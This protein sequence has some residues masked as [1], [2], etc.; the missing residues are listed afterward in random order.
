VSPL[1]LA[2]VI[3]AHQLPEQ[4][5]RLVRRLDGSETTFLLHVDRRADDAV[6]ATARAELVQPNVT[7]LPRIPCHWGTWSIVEATLSGIHRALRAD[8]PFDYLVLL[9]GQDY[10]IKT[11]AEI[12]TALGQAEGRSFVHH[13][14][15]PKPDWPEG[16]GRVERWHYPPGLRNRLLERAR[17]RWSAPRRVPS[18]LA[19]HGGAQFWGMSREAAQYV[20]DFTARNPEVVRFF[21]HVHVPDEIYFQ[22]VLASSPL[23][24]RLICDTLHFL[25]WYRRPPILGADDLDA[26]AATYYLFARKFDLR[27]DGEVLDLI[28]QRLLAG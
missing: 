11:R 28:D 24:S 6:L 15:L 13:V 3:L 22:T 27:V 21:H 1:R 7:F 20:D 16:L 4:L 26:L 18:G 25:E 12:E 14:P 9:S 5:V 2:Y 8:A 23:R 19:L 10:P 17:N